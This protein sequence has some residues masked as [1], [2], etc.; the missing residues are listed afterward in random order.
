MTQPE[1]ALAERDDITRGREFVGSQERG[2]KV[3]QALGDAP[4]G[5]TLTDVAGHVDLTRATARR[6]LLTL[7]ELGYVRQDRRL[8]IRE[9]G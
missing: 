4:A 9:I 1:T 8:F 6:F 7:V 2:L 5:L 3:M